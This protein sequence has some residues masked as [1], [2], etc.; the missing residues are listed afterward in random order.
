MT[1][2]STGGPITGAIA[3]LEPIPNTAVQTTEKTVQDKSKS[4][5]TPEKMLKKMSDESKNPEK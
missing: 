5:G 3:T 4:P 2:A 1:G